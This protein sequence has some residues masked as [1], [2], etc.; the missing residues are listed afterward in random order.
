MRATPEIDSDLS[1][2][3]S[4]LQQ[5]GHRQQIF[6][7]IRCRKSSLGMEL[8]ISPKVKA[9]RRSFSQFIQTGLAPE[10]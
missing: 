7:D 4:R 1:L 10:Q 5:N 3:I 2:S 9:I 8:C 6:L